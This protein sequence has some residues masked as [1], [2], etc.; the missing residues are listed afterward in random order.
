MRGFMK[1][2]PN[3]INWVLLFNTSMNPD[4]LDTQT[5]TDAVKEVHETVERQEKYP[6]LDL[7]NE[8]R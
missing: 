4:G 3:G 2:K 5:V 7:F 6:D 8:F 1:R